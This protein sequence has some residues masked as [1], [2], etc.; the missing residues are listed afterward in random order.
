[1]VNLVRDWNRTAGYLN[2]CIYSIGLGSEDYLNNYFLPRIY[3]SSTQYSSDQYANLLIQ[4]YAQYLRV[5]ISFCLFSTTFP[6]IVI[7]NTKQSLQPNTY[8]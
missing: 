2:R 8:K 7:H 4:Q 6:L 1:M 3:S 5:G